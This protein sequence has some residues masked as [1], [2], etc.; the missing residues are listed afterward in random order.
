[1]DQ[2]VSFLLERADNVHHDCTKETCTVK[3]SVYGYYPSKPVNLILVIV[4]GLS[5][6][7]HLYQGARSRAWTFMVALVVGTMT[8]V[9][10][11]IGRLLMRNDPFSKAYLGIQL[12]CLTVAPAFIAGGIYLTLKHIIIVYGAQFS[13]IKPTWYTRIF[14]FCDVM[15]ILIQTAGAAMAAGGGNSVT[16]GNDVM[17]VGLVSQVVTLAIFGLMAVDVFFRVRRHR[18]QF[19][20]SAEALRASKQFKGF[21]IA[22][23]VAYCTIFIRCVYRIAEMAGGWSNPIMQDQIAFIILDGAMCVVAVVAL[24]VFHPGFL[25][26]QSYAT[27]KAEK[28]QSENMVM[29]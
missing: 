3:E 24:N 28:M 23:G 8:E 1:M 29:A 27:I 5:L 6:I 25:F 16:I 22:V 10:G 4:F 14:I 20:P 11:Y 17:M 21:L 12:V 13:R 9:I 19:A 2:I 18:G 7:A 15:G 26:R